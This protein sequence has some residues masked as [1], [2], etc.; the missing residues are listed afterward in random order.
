LTLS[1]DDNDPNQKADT[2]NQKDLVHQAEQI[3]QQIIFN[4]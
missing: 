1:P 4:P 3:H 2:V